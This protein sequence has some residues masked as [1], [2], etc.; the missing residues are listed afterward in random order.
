MAT[1]CYC[2]S[3]GG[4]QRSI[5]VYQGYFILRSLIDVAADCGPITGQSVLTILEPTYWYWLQWCLSRIVVILAIVSIG[6][7]VICTVVPISC[8]GVQYRSYVF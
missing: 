2:I 5:M 8:Y 1:G 4:Q 6:I 3:I 7:T